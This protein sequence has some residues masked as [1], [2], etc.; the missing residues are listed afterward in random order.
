PVGHREPAARGLLNPPPPRP[1]VS[2]PQMPAVTTRTAPRAPV[3]PP[4]MPAP[5]PAVQ[6]TIGRIEVRAAAAAPPAPRGRS[7]QAGAGP[8]LTLDAYLRGR[9]GS[10]R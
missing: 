9:N 5:A 8:R 6:V 1:G 4:P 3:S 7:A 10:A 2:P